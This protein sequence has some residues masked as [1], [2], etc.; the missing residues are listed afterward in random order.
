MPQI[1]EILANPATW[2]QYG[3]DVQAALANL[4]GNA[5]QFPSRLS[6]SFQD[7]PGLSQSTIRG[8]GETAVAI[9][10]QN[11]LSVLMDRQMA[12]A[13]PPLP[14]NYI[15]NNS[16][17]NVQDMGPSYVERPAP[18]RAPTANDIIRFAQINNVPQEQVIPMIQYQ[19][20]NAGRGPSAIDLY[21]QSFRS[22]I[23]FEQ[24]MAAQNMEQ[25]GART[26]QK[27]DIDLAKSY[28]ELAQNDIKA[29]REM[30]NPAGI[31]LSPG[32]RFK[33]D[34]SGEVEPIP[35]SRLDKLRQTDIQK[36][37]SQKV[38]FESD[39]DK[40]IAQVDKILE[41]GKRRT[42]LENAVGTID[43]M[44][45]TAM[46]F[47]DTANAR[48]EIDRLK[49]M[50]SVEGLQKM[51][52]YGNS[53]GSIT[54]KEWP[55]MRSMIGNLDM[56]QGEENFIENLRQIRAEAEQAKAR[57]RGQYEQKIRGYG[58]EPEET[59]QGRGSGGKVTNQAEIQA[60]AK[61]RGIPVA[62]VMA[63]AVAKGYRVE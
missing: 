20:A 18:R 12:P 46:L 37:S 49:N 41:T 15:R 13:A 9:D 42:G 32:E 47:E 62:Q 34:G 27:Q 58:L 39:A 29:R 30:A 2:G 33:L 4:S 6:S 60:I 25:A 10:P 7:P 24:L 31:R 22:G 48:S 8:N 26:R 35:G 1:D 14:Q 56:A 51:R 28:Q 36:A 3:P 16:T 55:I 11:R 53:P 38:G 19:A 61:K 23:P 43:S 59:D 63:D 44:Y 52:S 40:I 21:T 17:G 45:P 54:E 57:V 50:A 5:T